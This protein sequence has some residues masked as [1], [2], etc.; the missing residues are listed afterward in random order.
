VEVFFL[1]SGYLHNPGR[2]ESNAFCNIRKCLRA[3][4][5]I[6][7]VC[8]SSQK[9]PLQVLLAALKNSSCELDHVA[10]FAW[11]DVHHHP[12]ERKWIRECRWS[13]L[14]LILRK[15]KLSWKV[16]PPVPKTLSLTRPGWECS[17]YGNRRREISFR[18]TGNSYHTFCNEGA[19][20]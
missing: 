8:F 7:I 2:R 6:G 14:H 10:C 16:I 15:G 4:S 19:P 13:F 9:V 17:V 11:S 12:G 20:V 18:F 3:F 5:W 1:P